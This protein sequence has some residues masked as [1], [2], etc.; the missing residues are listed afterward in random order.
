ME[1][2]PIL[3]L[4]KWNKVD[5]CEWS[6]ALLRFIPIQLLSDYSSTEINQTMEQKTPLLYLGFTFIHLQT[7]VL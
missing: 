3:L 5:G 6:L 7:G 4:W 2:T 1:N